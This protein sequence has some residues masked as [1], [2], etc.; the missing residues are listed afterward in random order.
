MLAALACLVLGGCGSGDRTPLAAE[1][2]EPLYQQA[3]QYERQGRYSE[4]LLS[5]R[6]VIDKRGEQAAAE[7]HLDAGNI[8]LDQMKNPVEAIY[9]F[10]K[11]LELQPNSKQ[12]QLVRERINTAFLEIARTL[13]ARPQENQLSR[14]VD[15]DEIARLR[16]ENDELKARLQT[17]GAAPPPRSTRGVMFTIPEPPR[18]TAPAPTVPVADDSPLSLAPPAAAPERAAVQPSPANSSSRAAPPPPNSA[19]PATARRTHTVAEKET[20][21]GISTRYYGN[22]RHVADILDANRDILPN[23]AALKPGMV[24]KIP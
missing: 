9:R 7:S 12:A 2:D 3:K 17:L 1:T 18:P 19:R 21:Y 4:A 16:A 5:Y 15:D 8:L 6:K 23:T 11:Y 10:R 20:L 24:L 13:P 14:A 22:G